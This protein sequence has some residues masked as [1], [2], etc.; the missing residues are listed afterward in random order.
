MRRW[1]FVALLAG[2]GETPPPEAPPDATTPPACANCGVTGGDRHACGV[3]HWC[4]TCRRDAGRTHRCGGAVTTHYCPACKTEGD[5]P[6]PDGTH[7]CGRTAPCAACDE[8]SN[9]RLAEHAPNHI[10]GRT[11]YCSTCRI[12]AL[13]G[14]SCTDH[15]FPCPTCEVERLAE[16]HKCRR[17]AYCGQC[18]VEASMVEGE[19][20]HQATMYCAT[21]D[22]EKL[23]PHGHSG[24]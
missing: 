16:N 17:S 1:L 18:G 12:D 6:V 21:C 13:P 23:R 20:R 22:A 11:R 5:R 24:R 19:H 15:T 14:H 9:G 2:C 7:D 3:T 4:S 10:C 8:L